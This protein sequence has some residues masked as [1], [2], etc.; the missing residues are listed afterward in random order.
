MRIASL[1]SSATEMVCG[2]GLES[3]LVAISHECDYPPSILDRPR[4]TRS[5]IDSAL[6]SQAID[7]A[8]RQRLRQGLPLYEIDE[9]ALAELQPDLLLTQSQCDV[10]AIRLEDVHKFIA[11]QP[12]LKN[13]KVI[14]LAPQSLSEVLADIQTIGDAG[15]RTVEV[16]DYIAK[17]RER[18]ERVQ[19]RWA[20]QANGQRPKVVCIEWTEP[21][22]VAGNWTPELIR[23][24]GGEPGLAEAG[25]HSPYV[26]WE[27]VEAFDPDVL[28]IAP[29]GFGLER[30][31]QEMEQLLAAG[32]LSKLR[33]VQSQR[34]FVLDGNALFNRSGPRLVDTVEV[35]ASL[36]HSHE[37][38][39]EAMTKSP[40]GGWFRRI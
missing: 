25:K 18:I 30:S 6:P 22:M 2:L 20:S 1:L 16:G 12:G 27:A 23:L 10:C 4:V 37:L 17:L 24:A 29:C 34:A 9:A 11:S 35:I 26:A 39:T 15:G 33:A 13:T 8:V 31:W 32:K 28:L 36:L 14:A 38:P 3:S 21:L 7:E 40:P 5:L 19:G